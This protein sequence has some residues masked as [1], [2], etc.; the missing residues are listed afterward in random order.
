MT[1]KLARAIILLLTLSV[2]LPAQAVLNWTEVSIPTT[3]NMSLACDV[4]LPTGWTD[5][6]VILIQTPY[7]KNL[8]HF[9]GLP[10]GIGMAQETMQYAIVIVDWRGFYGS[11]TALYAGAPS[12]GFDGYDVVEWVAGQAWCNGN[13]G[14][15][16]PSALGRVQFQT[17]RQQPPHL[18]CMVP[19]VASPLNNYL[20][21]YPNGAARTEYLEQLD[22][23]GFG[24]S[25]V[26]YAHP[27]QDLVWNVAEE[28]NNY[29]Q[30]IT[31]PTLMMGGWYDHNV[32]TMIQFFSSIQNLSAVDVREQHRLLMG[33]WVHGG[34]G[35]ASLGTASQGE[36]S[37]PAAA[38]WSNSQTFQFFDYHLKGFEN[39]WDA[40][41]K[42]RYFQMGD[43]TWQNADAWPVPEVNN[44]KLYFHNDG[45]VRSELPE[46][47]T[48]IELIY[49][50]S[51]PSP[52]IG[53][54]TLRA[55]L[56][57]G[58]YDQ[59]ALVESRE[60]VLIMTSGVLVN[61][62]VL[63]GAA[64]VQVTLST[65]VTDTDIAVRLCDVYPDG[66]SMLVS[67]GIYRL[68][69]LN[70]FTQAS[71]IALSPATDYSAVIKFSH[72]AIT[73]KA[74]HRIRV[75]I[76]G[77][78]YPR[79]NRNMNTGG[80]MYP[81]LN[82]D[83]LINAMIAHD[84]IK[85]STTSSNGSFL[86]LPL[87]NE[88]LINSIIENDNNTGMQIYPVPAID[89]LNI[90]VTDNNLVNGDVVITNQLG[91]IVVQ[92]KLNGFRHQLNIS[93]LAEG[94]Y[95]ITVMNGKK[96]MTKPFGVLRK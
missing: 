24:T 88:I 89:E 67:D 76:S 46:E 63:K 36:L 79:F 81:N 95:F 22:A 31:I 41:A 38:G 60:D 66:R 68:R 20:E 7:N 75:D 55:D 92:E 93:T 49:N 14:T 82:G 6:P 77:S 27:Y 62:V 54:P 87:Q 91:S 56:D 34:S 5:G 9:T 94:Q 16:G 8:Y 58:P 42:V 10:I 23:L 70:G 39:G 21:Y 85:L 52:T 90:V 53:G 72:T 84:V 96:S 2:V 65:D 19:Q 3:D 4:Y 74:G 47:L 43:N 32:E 83:T 26:I 30:Q 69:F 48:N 18:V 12:L 33:P 73:F 37:Y 13:V 1:S 61:D 11:A 40:T 86:E 80:E 28:A 78:N 29:P 57:Q 17:A 59:T 15:W 64:K 35:V 45:I 44:A 71:L 25:P 50:P 51:D